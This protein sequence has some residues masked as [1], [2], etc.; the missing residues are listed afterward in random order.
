MKTTD[1]TNWILTAMNVNNIMKKSIL[2][3][4]NEFKYN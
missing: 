3:W 4:F 1:E 2:Q